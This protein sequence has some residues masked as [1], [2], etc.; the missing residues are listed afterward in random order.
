MEEQAGN[1]QCQHKWVRDNITIDTLPPMYHRICSLCGRIEHAQE[2][3]TNDKT[4]NEVFRQFHEA[5]TMSRC[6]L[7]VRTPTLGYRCKAGH[8]L[9]YLTLYAWCNGHHTACP[10]YGRHIEQEQAK[11]VVK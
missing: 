9:T 6:P 2:P 1:V 3:M 8:A 10:D 11:E 4:F 7:L 5:P